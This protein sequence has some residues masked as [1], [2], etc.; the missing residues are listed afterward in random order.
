MW[1]KTDGGIP[2]LID[3]IF[4]KLDL[5]C[6]GM[7]A[8]D[9]LSVFA[10]ESPPN[11]AGEVVGL[12]RKK[13]G[14]SE[15]AGG[16]E[17]D[18]EIEKVDTNAG[19][20]GGNEYRAAAGGERQ[21]TPPPGRGDVDPA[22]IV[23]WGPV[24]PPP[25][26][27]GEGE[28]EC[29]SYLRGGVISLDSCRDTNESDYTMDTA[30]TWVTYET[31]RS[32]LS[33][34]GGGASLSRPTGGGGEGAAASTKLP[35]FGVAPLA[36]A[37]AAEKDEDGPLNPP[38]INRIAWSKEG[39]PS[40]E[41]MTGAE[42]R[43]GALDEWGGRLEASD[44]GGKYGSS[45]GIS[46]ARLDRIE[47]VD[48]M[49]PRDVLDIVTAIAN[50]RNYKLTKDEVSKVLEGLIGVVN[51]DLLESL[52]KTEEKI[53]DGKSK[54]TEFTTDT[55]NLGEDETTGTADLEASQIRRIVFSMF[56]QTWD[57][58]EGSIA[59]EPHDSGPSARADIENDKE[60]AND[61][62]PSK[63]RVAPKR[64]LWLGEAGVEEGGQK[65]KEDDHSE[66]LVEVKSA[67]TADFAHFGR[68][69][70]SSST[71][72]WDDAEGL[73]DNCCTDGT[74]ESQVPGTCLDKVLADADSVT[75][76]EDIPY[77]RTQMPT[78]GAA[79]VYS[80]FI[81]PVTRVQWSP[82]S[83]EARTAGTGGDESTTGEEWGEGTKMGWSCDE[84]DVPTP[85]WRGTTTTLTTA[86][87]VRIASQE[88]TSSKGERA[89]TLLSQKQMDSPHRKIVQG[90]TVE[91][92]QWGNMRG[93]MALRE[94]NLMAMDFPTKPEEDPKSMDLTSECDTNYDKGDEG[95]V[96][97]RP[98]GLIGNVNFPVSKGEVSKC[99]SFS[100]PRS[101]R[102]AQDASLLPREKPGITRK[103]DER[104]DESTKYSTHTLC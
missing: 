42:S 39:A 50:E 62:I 74:D 53:A 43:L 31:K 12:M 18:N 80:R 35:F 97:S 95:S 61:P 26:G 84:S 93:T 40:F 44:D 71:L 76:A 3:E 77:A 15:R 6:M 45:G 4:E 56:T 66:N 85:H 78:G 96:C 38:V 55:N 54:R 91:T 11:W 28:S 60:S 72:I 87:D 92:K 20:G 19:G 1:T 99:G 10:K 8:C 2:L 81:S 65:P 70:F 82:D 32:V 5:A 49:D 67:D 89:E 17:V 103:I 37:A 41:E 22:G 9:L 68:I 14:C 7:S 24:E 47:S 88:E 52:S 30:Y 63:S 90:D 27:E 102:F 86:V 79:Q 94:D 100:S 59:A 64:M 16:G 58:P 75:S 36:A 13:G 21:A 25:N 101:V 83:S 57:N 73:I 98:K 69:A 104:K 51:T 46:R 34:R 48:S 33:S 29:E 23:C